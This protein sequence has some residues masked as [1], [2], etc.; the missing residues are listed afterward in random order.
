LDYYN[1]KFTHIKIKREKA[2]KGILW[3]FLNRPNKKNAFSSGMINSLTEVLAHADYDPEIK[4]IILAGEGEAFSA[5]GDLREMQSKTGMFSGDSN[6]L[7]LNYK[8]GIQK[9]P[10]VMESL[11]TPVIAM[12]DGPAIGAG[13]DLMCMCDLRVATSKASFG[14]TFS[15][16][17]LVAGIGGTY[18]LTRLVGFGKAMEMTLTGKIYN[19]D[20]AFKIGLI[21]FLVEEKEIKNFTI[22]LAKKISK[23]GPIS[24]SMAK[25]ALIHSY[26]SDLG[27]QLELL[28]AFQGITQRTEDHQN[29]V[30]A[31]F[32]KS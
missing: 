18:F 5:G 16:L 24:I 29:R 31:F 15:K 21:N 12:V 20:D 13:L 28:A 10:Q 23:N 14:E 9:I 17:N 25:R 27:P 11:G 1:K 3:I 8:M 2:T 32:K 19:A 26:R 30:E 22:D 4:V 6:T 7:R